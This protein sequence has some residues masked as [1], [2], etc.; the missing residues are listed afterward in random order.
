M[1]IENPFEKFIVDENTPLDRELVAEIVEPFLESI[2]K[3]KVIRYKDRFESSSFWIK[4]GIYLCIRKIMVESE[5]INEEKVGPKEISEDTG[6]NYGTVRD[7]SRD[8]ILKKFVSKE[9]SKYYIRNHDLK[10]FKK[11]LENETN[12]SK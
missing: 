8:K 3:N 12:T 2:G 9:E 1:E 11:L 5:I 4:I 10:K 6:I 7:I